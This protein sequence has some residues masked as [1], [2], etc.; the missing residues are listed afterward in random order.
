MPSHSLGND[1]TKPQPQANRRAMPSALGQFLGRFNSFEAQGN[2]DDAQSPRMA[3]DGP[4]ARDAWR[5]LT[6]PPASAVAARDLGVATVIG[7]RR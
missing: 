7:S 1:R 6:R 3:A 2:G 4:Q 5:A